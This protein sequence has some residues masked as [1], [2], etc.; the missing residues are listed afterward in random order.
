[1][2]KKIHATLKRIA[3]KITLEYNIKV[4]RF[5]EIDGVVDLVSANFFY[6][7]Y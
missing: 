7:Y 5:G 6:Y 4:I 1:M 2:V 3:L